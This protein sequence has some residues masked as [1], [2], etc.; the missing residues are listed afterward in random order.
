MGNAD[1]TD[2]QVAGIRQLA[3]TLA[4]ACIPGTKLEGCTCSGEFPKPDPW[5][6]RYP[7]HHQDDCPWVALSMSGFHWD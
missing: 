5:G 3:T 4:E 1:L 2:E 6:T 7:L